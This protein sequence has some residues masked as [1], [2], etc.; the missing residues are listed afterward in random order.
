[1]PN[2]LD[3]TQR[4]ILE[5]AI[6]CIYKH[7]YQNVTTRCIAEEAGV[8]EVTIF[9]R[10]GTKAAVLDALFRYEAESIAA[11]AMYDSGDLEGD[12]ARIVATMWQ[13]VTTRQ[14]IIPILLLEFSRNPELRQQAQPSLAVIE[15]LMQI[16]ARYQADGHLQPGSPA[17]LF[18]SLIGP[19]I[20]AGL[21]DLPI[22]FD[23]EQYV[24]QFLRGYGIHHDR[25]S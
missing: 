20:F 9:R 13:A 18:A 21:I 19:L 14:S 6:Q 24:Q 11:Q 1:M 15:E 4:A 7:G 25:S 23:P 3:D 22:T 16:I 10:F 2:P 12:L 8:N 17:M 5:G